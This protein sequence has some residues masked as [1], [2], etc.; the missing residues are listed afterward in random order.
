MTTP[1]PGG[2]DVEQTVERLKALSDQAISMSK[3][4]GR[5][6]L[7]AYEHVLDSFLKLQSQAAKGTQ[8]EWVNTLANTNAEFVREVSQ[9][10]L[11]AVRDSLK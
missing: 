6:W 9:V 7:D 2:A 10:Y 5:N 8:V 1:T 11:T 4:N 3:E